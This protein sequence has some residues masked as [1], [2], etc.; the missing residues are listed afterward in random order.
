MHANTA[1]VIVKTA[2]NWKSVLLRNSNQ[3][4][5][6]C[7][8]SIPFGRQSQKFSSSVATIDVYNFLKTTR[9][10]MRATQ[11]VRQRSTKFL[12]LVEELDPSITAVS[13]T[14]RFGENR[15]NSPTSRSFV[16]IDDTRLTWEQAITHI[17]SVH[18]MSSER[19]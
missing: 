15:K 13:F 3:L 11:R 16:H 9:A 5:M 10:E 1:L 14:V 17:S 7:Q 4:L 12:D 8:H 6:K 18:V 2:M 19:R